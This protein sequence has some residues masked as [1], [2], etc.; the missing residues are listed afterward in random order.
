MI[1]KNGVLERVS[2]DEAI[3]YTASRPGDFSGK[4]A[5]IEL[6]KNELGWQPQVSFEEGVRRYI[7]WYKERED[8]RRRKWELT[9]KA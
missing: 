5:S 3:E 9:D 6:A 8:E 7:K 2:W 4:E 1:R